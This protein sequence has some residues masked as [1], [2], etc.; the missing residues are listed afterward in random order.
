M[1]T[2]GKRSLPTMSTTWLHG[3]EGEMR[4]VLFSTRDS[5]VP[6]PNFKADRRWA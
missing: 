2:N 3:M 6:H 4:K 1:D 5:L